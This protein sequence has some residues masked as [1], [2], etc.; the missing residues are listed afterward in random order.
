MSKVL[1]SATPPKH[2]KCGIEK[3]VDDLLASADLALY[4]AKASGGRIYRVYV[5]TLRAR[6]NGRRELDSELRRACT[7]KE[8][9]LHFQP[10]VRSSNGIVTG[11]EAL[12]RWNHPE[13]GILAPGAFIDALGESAVVMEAGRWILTNACKM[14]ASWRAKGLP[15]IRMGVNLFPAQFRNGTLLQDVEQ[16]LFESGLP[17]EALELEITENIALGREDGTLSELKALRSRGIGIAFDDFGTG[18]ASLS[19]L[20]L[21]PLTRIKIDR[22]F[23]QKIDENSAS[24][25]TAIVRSIIVM[26]RNLGLEVIAEG[27]ETLA[28]AEFLKMEGC[29]ELQGF[30][31]SKALPAKMF[32]KFLRLSPID[33]GVGGIPISTVAEVARGRR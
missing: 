30:L 23:V 21:Y 18:Y 20:T 24:E 26:G 32:E 16:A 12:L 19:Y 33:A 10:Q 3:N 31:F 2:K 9:V 5:P 4:D 6:A 27:V 25:E 8:F 17:P 29:Q 7:N 13:R 28:Q 1:P 22:S 11:A 14:A 15:H